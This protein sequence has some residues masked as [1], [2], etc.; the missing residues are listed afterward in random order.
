MRILVAVVSAVVLII[1]VTILAKSI[2]RPGQPPSRPL[3]M[4]H[5]ASLFAFL[6]VVALWFVSM[7]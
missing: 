3:L 2:A 5:L 4:V 6:A 1:A 7:L